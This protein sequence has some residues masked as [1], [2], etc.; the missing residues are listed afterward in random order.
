M[1]LQWPD[2][3]EEK[4]G[5]MPWKPVFKSTRLT[6]EHVRN[7]LGTGMRE[8]GIVKGYSP[9]R[10]DPLRRNVVRGGGADGRVKLVTNES[11]AS[12]QLSSR[13]NRFFQKTMF[14]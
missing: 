13:L 8:N 12:S 1:T 3:I 10:H 5:A 6:F 9:L 4:P 11:K 14:A 2:H 7:A